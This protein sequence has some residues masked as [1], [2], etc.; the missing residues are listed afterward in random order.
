MV[1]QKP[2][3]EWGEEVMPRCG[4]FSRSNT[5]HDRVFTQNQFHIGFLMIRKMRVGIICVGKFD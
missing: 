5:Y 1:A 3:M 4:A 2:G